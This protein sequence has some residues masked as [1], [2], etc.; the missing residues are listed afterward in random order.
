MAG[1]ESGLAARRLALAEA[2]LRADLAEA[3]ASAA[4]ARAVARAWRPD[5]EPGIRP[6]RP[7]LPAASNDVA[8]TPPGIEALRRDTEQARLEERL[9]GRV[10]TFPE[11]QVGWQRL[12]FRVE[13]RRGPYW[14][15]AWSCLSSTATEGPS[16]R[17]PRAV[18]PPKPGW[19]FRP[20]AWPPGGRRARG[21][22]RAGGGSVRG[23][24]R[25]HGRRPRRRRRDGG[26][27]RGRGDRH[28]PDR[29]AALRTRGA[30]ARSRSPR[31]RPWPP[32]G[33][34]KPRGPDF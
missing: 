9:S 12:W 29:H 30:D 20:H 15:P 34:S 8:V 7:T 25:R 16:S 3:E 11:I 13:R 10:W 21:P 4:R 18:K 17:P 28:R 5:L 1:E 23:A 2:E 33:S 6:M 31:R 14:A 32:S 22:G 26:L 27:P 24:A 19:H